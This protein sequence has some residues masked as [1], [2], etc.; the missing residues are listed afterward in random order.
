LIEQQPLVRCLSLTAMASLDEPVSHLKLRELMAASD[1]ET[2]YGAFRALQILD[3]HDS[4]IQGEL[5]NDCFWLHR[6]APQ[7]SP[8]V[9]LSTNRRAEVVLFGDDAPLQA[10][11]SFLAGEFTLTAGRNDDRC[12]ISRSSV[13]HGVD[14]R[15]CSLKLGTV[16]QNLAEMGAIY[17]EVVDFLRQAGEFHCLNCPLAID[18]LPQATSIFDLA[19][20][21]ATNPQLLERIA[22]TAR[23][24]GVTTTKAG[25]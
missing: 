13:R 23:N 6:V 5:L 10:P 7:S 18:A 22:E 21:G 2:R 20:D 14:H 17:P 3:E 11:F 12:T 25:E 16:L 4:A 8:L 9:H 15:Q 19:Q 1:A 24:Q